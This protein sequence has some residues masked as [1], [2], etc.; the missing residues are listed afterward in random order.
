MLHIVPIVIINWT[1]D[2]TNPTAVNVDT[3]KYY[4]NELTGDIGQSILNNR[5]ITKS[6]Y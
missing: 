3:T 6:I 5:Y 2:F 1:K 4:H